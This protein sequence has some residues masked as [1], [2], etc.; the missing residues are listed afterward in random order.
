MTADCDSSANNVSGDWLKPAIK[1]LSLFG[2]SAAAGADAGGVVPPPLP[3]P[4]A[5][6]LAEAEPDADALADAEPDA[7]ALADGRADA[8]PDAL[9]DALADV[10]ARGD[11]DALDEAASEGSADVLG[12]AAVLD[13]VA[14]LGDALPVPD[15]ADGLAVPL[16]PPQA[17]M[18]GT[19]M[20]STS[21][22]AKSVV[23]REARYMRVCS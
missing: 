22:R 20:A 19:S 2:E 18:I 23:R 12:D 9:P 8:E 6:G 11:V 17:A 16:P 3:E 15:E 10:D 4:D 7:D 13:D 1:I 21:V 14:A 5:D